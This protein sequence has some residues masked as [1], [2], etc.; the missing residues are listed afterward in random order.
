MIGIA[1]MCYIKC[2]KHKKDDC[3]KLSIIVPVHNM[4]EDGKLAFCIDSLLNQTIN[5]YEIITV[6]DASTDS[7]LTVLREYEK[8]NPDKIKVIA[9][10]ENHRQGGAKNYALDICRGEYIG[11]IDSDD[12]ILPDMYERLINAAETE[13]ADIAACNLTLVHEKSFI[14]NENLHSFEYDISGELTEDKKKSII[15]KHGALVTKVYKRHIFEEPKLRFPDHMF[16]EDNAIGVEVMFRAKRIAYIDE[17]MYFYYQHL[18]STV[19]TISLDRCKD[20]MEAMRI[21][22]KLAK[23]GNYFD[24]FIKE[25]EYRYATLFYRN[26]LFSYMQGNG[27][28]SFSFIKAMGKEMKE[29]FPEFE[30]NELYLRN[31]D[32]EERKFMSL[33]QKSTLLFMLYY[34]ALWTYRRIRYGK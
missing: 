12:W 1:F 18:G 32:S 28:H 27:H 8:K 10:K 19:H 15:L 2:I 14:P 21:M 26:T 17:P 7:S 5:E 25:F 30:K 34:K 11:F 3:M 6:D 29:T 31:V 23:E 20:R 24:G 9:L 22:L 4:A 16:Y 13:N 33:Q